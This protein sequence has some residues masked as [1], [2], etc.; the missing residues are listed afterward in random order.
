[1]KGYV[2]PYA[3]CIQASKASW[4][5][6]LIINVVSIN[7]SIVIH[8][9]I[10]NTNYS[11]RKKTVPTDSIKTL[12]NEYFIVTDLKQSAFPAQTLQFIS[13]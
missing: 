1:M 9:L 7:V 10:Y 6:T 3:S 11:F 12:R 8:E 2:C 13:A 4:L 5:L